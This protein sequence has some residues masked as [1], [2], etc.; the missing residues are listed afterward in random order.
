MRRQCWLCSEPLDP[1]SL[2]GCCAHHNALVLAI[3]ADAKE[4]QRTRRGKVAA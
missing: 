3:A 4:P 1:A 2:V